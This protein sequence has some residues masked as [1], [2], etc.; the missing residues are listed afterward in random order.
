MKIQ[1]LTLNELFNILNGSIKGF[2][3]D[4]CRIIHKFYSIS[5]PKFKEGDLGL[6]NIVNKKKIF[7]IKKIISYSKKKGY[8][9]QLECDYDKCDYDKCDNDS[10]AY[11]NEIIKLT[12]DEI[13]KFNIFNKM[14][15]EWLD[16]DDDIL[17]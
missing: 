13:N 3:Y 8:L 14:F 6:V 16:E 9:Y 4:I 11:E 12:D 7:K 17:Y 1:I 10:F 2:N 15:S 5:N